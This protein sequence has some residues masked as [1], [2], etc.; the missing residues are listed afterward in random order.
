MKKKHKKPSTVQQLKLLTAQNRKDFFR[1]IQR[2]LT[3][4]SGDEDTIKLFP[5]DDLELLF[6]N[7]IQSLKVESAQGHTIDPRI[8]RDM[9]ETALEMM[10]HEMILTNDFGGSITLLEFLTD[11]F[12]ILMNYNCYLDEKKPFAIE[13]GLALSTYMDT[14]NVADTLERSKKTVESVTILYSD[15]ASVL[16]YADLSPK[17]R[18]WELGGSYLALKVYSRLQEKIPITIDGLTRPAVRVGCFD[19]EDGMVWCS[20][21]PAS[22][23]IPQRDITDLWPVYIQM[24]ALQRLAER[25]NCIDKEIAQYFLYRSI[26]NGRIHTARD[27]HYLIE[28]H[29]MDMK[30]GYLL[31]LAHDNML[32]VRTFLFL[33]N[34]GTPEG[35][36]LHNLTGLQ[37]HDKK[38][39]A[40]DKLSTFMDPELCKNDVIQRLFFDAGCSDLFEVTSNIGKGHDATR[41]NTS[42]KVLIEYLMLNPAKPEKQTVL[43]PS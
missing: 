18:S 15:M 28:Y 40:L 42:S 13:L 21:P 3:L 19:P 16:Y 34:N 41:S 24:H 10:K 7:R 32:V 5:H 14:D 9:K 12:T 38:Y 26:R 37:K 6:I 20:R 1:R 25:L 35:K 8:L 29:F 33:T 17:V 30:L 43:N 31:V 2:I 11:V 39:L 23:G 27:N 36:K 22:F 4:L